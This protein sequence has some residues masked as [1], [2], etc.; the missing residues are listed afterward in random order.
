MNDKKLDQILQQALTPEVNDN[1]I[2]VRFEKGEY[3]MKKKR[4]YVRPAIALVACA[5][6]V[7][8][9]GFGNLADQIF[10]NIGLSHKTDISTNKPSQNVES[11]FVMKVKAAEIKELKKGE[12]QVAIYSGGTTGEAWSGSDQNKEIGYMIDLPLICEGEDMDTIT[13]SVNKGCFRVLQPK[14]KPYVI[15]GEECGEPKQVSSGVDIEIAPEGA[16][17]MEAKYYKTFTISAKDQ[18][19]KDVEVAICDEKKLSK[20]LY[21]R[22]WDN[23]TAGMT[24]EEIMAEAAVKNEVLDSPQVTCKITYQGDSGQKTET[25]KVAVHLE[26]MTYKEAAGSC[27][28]KSLKKELEQL[29]DT[30]GIFTAFERL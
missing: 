26:A 3:S 2:K 18:D 10:S 17:Q 28:D 20:E 5:A 14:N 8:G 16:D 19:R 15:K 24:D 30:M 7:A 29:K 25:A 12:S 23:N 4:N 13:Y 6:L 27:H 21:K 22:L 9:I 11:G 1:E